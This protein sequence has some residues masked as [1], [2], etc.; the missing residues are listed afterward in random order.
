MIKR[1]GTGREKKL[2]FPERPV[3]PRYRKNSSAAVGHLMVRCWRLIT[4]SSWSPIAGRSVPLTAL[5]SSVSVVLSFISSPATPY[6]AIVRSSE[7]PNAGRSVR[8]I[9]PEALGFVVFAF[10][11][12]VAR[13]RATPPSSQSSH[14]R[15]PVPLSQ[16]GP[17][18]V[19]TFSLP[20]SITP[21]R[22]WPSVDLTF[23]GPFMF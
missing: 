2:N 11:S 5:D 19:A 12:P 1:R 21:R 14:A 15:R 16:F 9:Q 17:L 20:L 13:R 6:R 8:L 10:C 7:P 4:A 23:H 3:Y 18:A 22:G